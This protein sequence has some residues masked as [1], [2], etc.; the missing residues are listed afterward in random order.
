MTSQRVF[1][2]PDANAPRHALIVMDGL[3]AGMWTVSSDVTQRCEML[4]AV[5]H[6]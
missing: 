3:K 6:S 5:N 2:V 1:S 4:T